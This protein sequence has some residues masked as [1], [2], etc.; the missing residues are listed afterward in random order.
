MSSAWVRRSSHL[1]AGKV[2]WVDERME[3]KWFLA[4]RISRSAVRVRWLLGA[5]YWMCRELLRNRLVRGSEVSLSIFKAVTGWLRVLKNDRAD[6]N[7][8]T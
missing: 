2:R 3:M 4:V 1:L 5:A 7:A 6:V 8:T